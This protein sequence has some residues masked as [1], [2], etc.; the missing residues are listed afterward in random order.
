MA[1]VFE[2]NKDYNVTSRYQILRVINNDGSR[3]LETYNQMSVPE[4][5]D[6]L[7][8]V[9]QVNE[10]GRLDI[11]AQNQYGDSTYWWA[12]ALANEFVDPF[13]VNAGTLV[14]IPRIETLVDPANQILERR[15]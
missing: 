9:V 6:D 1:M 10:E 4:R 5:D 13:S 15:G 11:I 2:E 3:Y 12:I 7:Y 14:R 8:H